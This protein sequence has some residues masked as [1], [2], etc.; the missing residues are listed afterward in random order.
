MH[1]VHVVFEFFDVGGSERAARNAANANGFLVHLLVNHETG[2]GE[3][4]LVATW[5][6]AL[7][8]FDSC[9]E[10]KNQRVDEKSHIRASEGAA[11]L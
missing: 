5:K 7:E 8:R 3:K 2:L 9:V 6:L 1:R 10:L 11:S 4:G